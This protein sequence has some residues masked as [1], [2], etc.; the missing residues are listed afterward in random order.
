LGREISDD[1]LSRGI[2][3]GGGGEELGKKEGFPWV[4]DRGSPC[5]RRHKNA[6][7]GLGGKGDV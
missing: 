7:L 3:K 6:L 1:P 2:R 5:V 4:P